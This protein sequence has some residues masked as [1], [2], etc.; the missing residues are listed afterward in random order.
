MLAVLLAVFAL[1]EL[2]SA[3]PIAYAICQAGC[4]GLVVACYGAAGAT[5]GTVVAGESRL[6]FLSSRVDP[7]FQGPAT[8]AII[9]SCN[10]AFGSCS[11]A[12][13]TAALLAPT[14]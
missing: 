1:A 9:I 2:A 5:F 8:P 3:G 7:G 10:S 11:A 6:S 4:S 13:A 14:P 12:C